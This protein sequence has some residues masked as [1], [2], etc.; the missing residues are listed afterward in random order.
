MEIK[1]GYDV[2]LNVNTQG[3]YCINLVIDGV[4]GEFFGYLEKLQD[5][6]EDIAK[7]KKEAIEKVEYL[8]DD[9]DGYGGCITAYKIKTT[10][11]TKNERNQ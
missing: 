3:K 2:T 9:V 1:K 7:S 10:R 11:R 5:N 8:P 4:E 6:G